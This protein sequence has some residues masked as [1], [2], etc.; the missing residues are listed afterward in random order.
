MMTDG[1]MKDPVEDGTVEVELLVG[2]IPEALP[3]EEARTRKT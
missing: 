3:V 2:Q 1:L